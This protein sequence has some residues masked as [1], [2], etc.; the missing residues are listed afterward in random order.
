MFEMVLSAPG[1]NALSTAVL[2]DLRRRLGEARGEPVLLTGAG[3]AFCAGLNLK[4][5]AALDL[6]GARRLLRALEGFVDAL[7]TYP[8]PAVALV[9]GHAIAGGCILALCC[10]HRVAASD[11]RIRIG[12]NETAL[13]LPFPP[14]TLAMVRS[15]V[16]PGALDR[17]ILEAGLH[18]PAQ[19]RALGLVD[20]VADDARAVAVATLERLAGHPRDAYARN[21]AR[22]REGVLGAQDRA[23]EEELAKIWGSAEIRA[24]AAA[25]L[26]GKR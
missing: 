13:G 18:P 6:D 17:V 12:L 19:A 21:K 16:P 4:E 14:K 15:R 9:N 2:E 7:F 8:A 23:V 10:D 11:P 3:D 26:Q 20:E 24:R 1:K 22:L 25:A 5:V